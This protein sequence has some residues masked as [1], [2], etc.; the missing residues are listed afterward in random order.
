M[1]TFQG[2]CFTFQGLKFHTEMYQF[3]EQ[4]KLRCVK[5]PR[6]PSQRCCR[7]GVGLPAPYPGP[8]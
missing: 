6:K 7:L 1:E 5:R 3:Y 2:F 8:S 4:E